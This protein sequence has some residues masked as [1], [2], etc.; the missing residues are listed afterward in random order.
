MNASTKRIAR[1]GLLTALALVLGLIDRA[2]PLTA[3]LGGAVPGIKLGLANTVLLYAVYLMDWKSCVLLM[4][5]KVVLSG[6]LFGSLTA[7][8]YSLSGGVLSLLVMLL[9]RRKPAAGALA[10]AGLAIAAD[11]WLLC[12]NPHPAGQRLLAVILIAAAFAASIAVFILIRKGIIRGVMGTSLSG[13][14]AHNVGQVLMACFVLH[15]PHPLVTYLPFL[16]AIGAAVGCL[17]GIVTER[18]LKALKFQDY[19]ERDR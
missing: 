3:L 17:T 14:I 12:R 1:F 15:S 19:K 6:F 13:A 18:V 9:V 10:A 11:T 4:L 8:L 2:V 7:I 16:V 5:T